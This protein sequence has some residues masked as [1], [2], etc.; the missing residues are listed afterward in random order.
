MPLYN[1]FPPF[2]PVP[3]RTVNGRF[4]L[5]GSSTGQ[6]SAEPVIIRTKDGGRR[7]E[8]VRDGFSEATR[9]FAGVITF[10]KSSPVHLYTGSKSGEIYSNGDNGNH[11]ARLDMTVASISNMK[12]V[13]S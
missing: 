11:W 7:W 9:S 4:A 6:L 1:S 10:D 12:C 5:Y 2:H 8:R 13:Q 3:S